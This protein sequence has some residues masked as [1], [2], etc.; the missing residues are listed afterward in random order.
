MGEELQQLSWILN[1]L[2]EKDKLTVNPSYQHDM[3][4]LLMSL[5]NECIDSIKQ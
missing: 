5:N 3:R 4:N 1:F 2:R